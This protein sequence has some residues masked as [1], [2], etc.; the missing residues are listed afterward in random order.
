MNID[1]INSGEIGFIQIIR[2]FGFLLENGYS[3]KEFSIGGREPYVC[4]KS[5]VAK[6]EIIVC[7]SEGGYLD[8]CIRRKKIFGTLK[9]TIFSIRDYYKYFNC[10]NL[11]THPP[12][13][14]FNILKA[15]ADI[16]QQYLMPII[17]GEMWIDELL[18]HN[19]S[20]HE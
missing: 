1:E 18:K 15:N 16:V 5:W 19:K 13:G 17:K 8:V 20:I 10:E 7:W 3:G 4:F 9:S 11:K 6:R 2:A 12:V 14:A